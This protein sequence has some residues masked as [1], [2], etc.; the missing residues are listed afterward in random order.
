[1][2][3]LPCYS[4]CM[5]CGHSNQLGA[6]VT[7]KRFEHHVEGEYSGQ[8]QH[9]SYQGVIHGGMI[10]ALLDESIGW[11]VSIHHQKMCVTGGLN[12]QFKKPIAPGQK[13]FV[14]GFIDEISGQSS[15]YF[16]GNGKIIDEEG[17]VYA[18]AQGQ[19]FPLTDHQMKEVVKTMEHRTVPFEALQVSDLWK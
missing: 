12:V 8:D 18:K 5:T 10:T 2:R 13:V 14:K 15:K 7:W 9:V 3:D 17:N 1:M 11:A 6:N 19:F 4:G 16:S